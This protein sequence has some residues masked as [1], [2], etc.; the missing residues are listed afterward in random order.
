RALG[1]ATVLLS[2]MDRSVAGVARDCGR[3]YCVGDSL[4]WMRDHVPD[5]FRSA[6]RYWVQDFPGVRARAAGLRPPPTVVGPIV[7]P[8]PPPPMGPGTGLVVNLGGM[9]SPDGDG[10]GATR[11]ADFVVD[12]L[13]RSGLPARF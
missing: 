3:P 10:D 1:A 4:L 12:G 8:L 6:A 13:L 2:V 11:Y 5:V 7:P 9:E